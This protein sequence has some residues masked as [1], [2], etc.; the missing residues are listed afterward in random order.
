MNSGLVFFSFLGCGGGEGAVKAGVGI[1]M[2][3]KSTVKLLSCKR[4]SLLHPFQ[5]GVR[6]P[7][8][9]TL[10]QRLDKPFPFAAFGDFS[11]FGTVRLLFNAVIFPQVMS[12]P[13][14]LG[15]FTLINFVS[16]NYILTV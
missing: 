16:V 8:T 3:F 13:L 9:G 2:L 12:S 7:H 15:C 11:V 10:I 14:F 6:E 1:G 4:Q 5:E